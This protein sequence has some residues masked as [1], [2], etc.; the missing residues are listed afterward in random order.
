M[1]ESAGLSTEELKAKRQM[2]KDDF[3]YYS[4][5]CLTIKTKHEGNQPLILNKA[6]Q[7]IHDCVEE[8]L[9]R[10]G[11][12][13]AILLKGRQQGG[14]TYVEGRFVW[15]VTHS[16]SVDAY[17]LTHE[18][19]ATQNLFNMSKRYIEYLP[20]YVKP[21]QGK[22][23]SNELIFD[24]LESGFRVGTAGNKSVGRSMTNQL[25]H[26]SE[27]AFWPNA[28][29]HAKGI[30]QTVPDADGTEVIYESTANGLNNF[31]HQQWKLAEEG[32]SEFIPIFVPWYWQDEYVKELPDD[33][34]MDQDEEELA[35]HYELTEEQIYWRRMKIVELSTDG[36]DGDLSFKQEYPMNA[37][38]AFQ[39]TGVNGLI[40]PKKVLKARKKNIPAPSGS[41]IVGVDPSRGGDRFSTIK[42]CG[43]KAYDKRSWVGNDVDAL[44]KMV[45]KCKKILDTK[46]L[47]ANRRPDMMF[48]DAGGG[49]DLVD[50]LHELSTSENDYENRVKAIWFGG[51]PLDEDKYVNRRNEMWGNLNKWLSDENRQVDIPDDD[52]LHADIC[53]CP[54]DLNSDN[55]KV[56]WSKDRIKKEFGFSPDEGDAL[57][58]TFAEPVKKV[59]ATADV[60]VKKASRS[61]TRFDRR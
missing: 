40:T 25:F 22:A 36:E 48:I 24:K 33:F 14:S 47:V 16:K 34:F 54:Y 52:I 39:V 12:V 31:F 1:V 21:H 42:R 27:V 56:L 11:K 6:Q 15:K 17:I 60:K 20:S 41:L 59:T 45:A 53:A 19:K 28:A 50:R 4:R 30:L 32:K 49:A 2:L 23:N 44:P 38:E 26:G 61:A 58:L 8:Q 46:C 57:A 51:S 18:D 13:R 43:R 55:Q 5:N 10:T 37:A 9:A 29:E 7:Y 35:N 3:T